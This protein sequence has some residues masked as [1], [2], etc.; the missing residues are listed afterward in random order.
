MGMLRR[1]NKLKLTSSILAP[2]ADGLGPVGLAWCAVVLFLLIGCDVTPRLDAKFE[3]DQLGVPP[4]VAPAPSPPNDYLVFRDRFVTFTVVANSVGEHL[5]RV[6][7]LPVFTASPDDRRVFLIAGTEQFTTSPPANIRGTVRLRL[8][9]IGTVG[10][11]FRISQGEQTLDDFIGGIELSNF[12]PPSIGSIHGLHAFHYIRLNDPL[13]LPSSGLISSYN[14]G[15]VIDIN[16]S[17]D[18]ATHIFSAGVSGNPLQSNSFPAVSAGIATTPIQRLILYFWMQTPSSNT[19]A[20]IDN[21]YAEEF[22]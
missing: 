14:S 6:Q 8:D 18:Q 13:G 1:K 11:G 17:I 21:L 5:L 9:N 16:W 7:P 15:N 4:S 19:V 22:R 10:I 3:T 12:L 20:F 2:R